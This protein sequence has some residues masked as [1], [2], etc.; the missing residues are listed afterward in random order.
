METGFDNK[1]PQKNDVI[2]DF[3]NAKNDK[4]LIEGKSSFRVAAEGTLLGSVKYSTK[5]LLETGLFLH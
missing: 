3:N 2:G 4:N 5:L 1:I